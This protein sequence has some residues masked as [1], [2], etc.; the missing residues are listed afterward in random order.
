MP[1]LRKR[2]AGCRIPIHPIEAGK[3]LANAIADL[4]SRS[5]IAAFIRGGCVPTTCRSSLPHWKGIQFHIGTEFARR[6][7]YISSTRAQVLTHLNGTDTVTAKLSNP[8][9]IRVRFRE[10]RSKRLRFPYPNASRAELHN[11]PLAP[12]FEA[13][14]IGFRHRIQRTYILERACSN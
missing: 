5:T 3:V 11:P 8:I 2:R 9:C 4:P 13:I 12:K 14:T 7:E 10:R 6:T 1:Y